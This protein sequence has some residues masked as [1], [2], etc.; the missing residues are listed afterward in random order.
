MDQLPVEVATN[1]FKEA[2]FDDKAAGCA[3]ALTSKWMGEVIKPVRF[4]AVSLHGMPQIIGFSK[5]LEGL[6]SAPKMKHLFVSGISFKEAE[7]RLAE[8]V[9]ELRWM[10]I[11][12]KLLEKSKEVNL[13]VV[14][15][16]E[17]DPEEDPDDE[18]AK[19][20]EEEK[21]NIVM[22]DAFHRIVIQASASLKTLFLST[23]PD[24]HYRSVNLLPCAL[25]NL[26]ECSITESGH[27]F[28]P[29]FPFNSLKRLHLDADWDGA[30]FQN[31]TPAL[32]E[33]RFTNM[34]SESS[35]LD[36]IVQHA[37][38]ASKAEG[39]SGSGLSATVKRVVLQQSP[40]PYGGGCGN[41]RMNHRDCTRELNRTAAAVDNLKVSERFQFVLLPIPTLNLWAEGKITDGLGFHF[42]DARRDWKEAIAIRG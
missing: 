39:N 34:D 33:L 11:D 16:Q 35:L 41:S 14:W 20:E 17:E 9:R 18:E 40:P 28:M 3:L 27:R 21:Q 23:M 6:S 7:K 13:D 42:E 29:P 19:A 38:L 32:Q 37:R 36:A 22:N 31:C 30:Y 12:R 1:I 2:C 5:L 26:I 15:N 8:R 4:V 24:L 10:A 25:P